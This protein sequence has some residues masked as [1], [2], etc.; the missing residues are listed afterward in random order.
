MPE[1]RGYYGGAKAGETVVQRLARQAGQAVE[2][3]A[4]AAGHYLSKRF[5]TQLYPEDMQ[6]FYAENPPEHALFLEAAWQAMEMPVVKL[7]DRVVTP[8]QYLRMAAARSDLPESAINTAMQSI[9][10]MP[11]DE[12]DEAGIALRDALLG[13]L[14]DNLP[15]RNS[16]N[17]WDTGA[18]PEQVAEFAKAGPLESRYRLTP[19]GEQGYQS[20]RVY[21]LF[22]TFQ[23]GEFAPVWSDLGSKGLA[24]LGMPFDNTPEGGDTGYLAFSRFNTPAG[25]MRE[26]M[27]W[28]K[29][30]EPDGTVGNSLKG[31]KYPSLSFTTLEGATTKLD[32][33]DHL[34]PYYNQQLPERYLYN[35][36]LDAGERERL[37]WMRDDL[38]R[39]TP[40]YPANADPRE[41]RQLIRDLRDFDQQARG[42]ANAEYPE[43]VR[44]WTLPIEA[45]TGSGHDWQGRPSESGK[46]TPVEATFL[47]PFGEMLANYP[48]DAVDVQTVATLGLGGVKGAPTLLGGLM[49]ASKSGTKAVAKRAGLSA[50]GAIRRTVDNTIGDLAQEVPTN[51]AMQAANQ[52]GPTRSTADA[53]SAFFTPM[54]TSIVTDRDGNPVKANDPNYRRY[55]DDAYTRRKS[56]LRGLLD[57]STNLYGR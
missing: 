24:L 29:E 13:Q 47:S 33:T 9:A 37:Q 50:A 48:R 14:R 18:T 19:E 32:S 40:R 51:T 28:W 2:D 39:I 26:S 11:F 34:I 55:L 30:G 17:G 46:R 8:S 31:A 25:R 7:G 56:E 44:N 12:Q 35:L 5:D 52:P 20:E 43:F 42:F 36:D 1:S 10:G 23:N 45:W 41:M 27:Y 49:D 21:N 54:E 57:R 4:K 16:E 15:G 22:T 53:L 6:A 3:S 38:F